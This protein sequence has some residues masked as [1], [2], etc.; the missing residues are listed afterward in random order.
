MK[1]FHYAA[2]ETSDRLKAVFK[3]VK[4]A[5][6]RGITGAELW[7][8]CRVLNPATIISEINANLWNSE[9]TGRI[10]CE[11]HGRT[12]AGRKVYRYFHRPCETK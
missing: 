4:K 10:S 7:Q 5:G 2:I 6:K 9:P 11:Y 1:T 8:E 12:K 3:A